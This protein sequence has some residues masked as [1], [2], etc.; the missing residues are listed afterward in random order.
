MTDENTRVEIGRIQSGTAERRGKATAGLFD[1]H[2]R[3][4]RGHASSAASSSA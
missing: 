2:S 4:D 1:G 3:R